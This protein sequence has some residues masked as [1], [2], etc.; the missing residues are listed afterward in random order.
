MSK[1]LYRVYLVLLVLAAGSWW[2]ASLFEPKKAKKVT[3][4]DHSPD[5]FSQGYQ[6]Q[7]MDAMGQLKTELIADK[8]THYSDDGTTHLDNPTMTLYHSNSLV[9]PWLIHAQKGLL[10][11][12]H[13]HLLLGGKVRIERQA[14]QQYKALTII[15][16]DLQV[17]LSTSRAKTHHWAMIKDSKNSTQGVGFEA[18]F[19]QPIKLK[20]LSKVKGRYVFH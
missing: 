5:Y 16:S 20:F 15:T 18:K 4:I 3:V 13:D 10:E 19:S 8:M 12:D 14:N 11:A 17:K 6:K 2:L 7:E 1:P 9:P